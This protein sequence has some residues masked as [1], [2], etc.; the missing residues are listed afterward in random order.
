MSNGEGDRPVERE[1]VPFR[2]VT[3]D[4]DTVEL[5][6]SSPRKASEHDELSV[7]GELPELVR[8]QP[9]T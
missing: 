4:G 7:I 1:E 2:L 8:G 5:S 9:G 6:Y 3:A